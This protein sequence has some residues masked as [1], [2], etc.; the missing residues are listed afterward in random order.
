MAE[1]SLK[2]NDT[3]F[4]LIEE[5]SKIHNINVSELVKSIIL[6][7]IYDDISVEEE[8]RIYKL[9]QDSKKEPKYSAKSVFDEL[10]I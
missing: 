10:G 4:S 6:D 9:W 5:Y 8:N 2:L 7:K 3:E 1:L